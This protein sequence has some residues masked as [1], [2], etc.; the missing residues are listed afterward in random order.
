MPSPPGEPPLWRWLQCG[1]PWSTRSLH[2]SWA[3]SSSRENTTTL[4]FCLGSFLWLAL[5][6]YSSSFMSRH[7]PCLICFLCQ[8]VSAHAVS[9][10]SVVPKQ[11]EILLVLSPFS[12]FPSIPLK[13][14]C[15]SLDISI[16]IQ[17]NWSLPWVSS[18]KQITDSI[19]SD[20]TEI[21]L[22]P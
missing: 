5:C 7:C 11:L 4:S 21:N 15:F 20:L 19:C 9:N 18:H 6:C 3:A 16:L 14:S 13:S 2:T 1:V 10:F 8:S 17:K 22:D 12:Q